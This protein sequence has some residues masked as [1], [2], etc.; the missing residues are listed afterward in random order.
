MAAYKRAN[1][2]P[3]CQQ[4]HR[5]SSPL[6]RQHHPGRKCQPITAQ[7]ARLYPAHLPQASA[8]PPWPVTR[9]SAPALSIAPG[10]GV[11]LENL[12]IPWASGVADWG[13]PHR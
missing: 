12:S 7:Q 13:E 1:R 8:E 11:P 3:D 2:F 9:S 4:R 10:P 5:R 6:H